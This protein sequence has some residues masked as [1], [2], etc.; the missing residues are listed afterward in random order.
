MIRVLVAEDQTLLRGAL[1]EILDRDSDI[2][3]VAQCA[4]GDDVLALAQES[5]PDVAVLDIE[6]P[7]LDGLEVAGLLTVNLPQVRV[8]VLT[9][10]GRPGYL[11]RAMDKGVLGF[12]LKDTPPRDLIY[13]IKKTAA[14]ER[15]ID[16][17]LALTTLERGQSPL[18]AR[19]QE[20]LSLSRTVATTAELARQVNL[21]EGSVRNVLSLA[22]QKLHAH[23]RAQAAL[24]AEENGWL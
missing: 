13:A 5:L 17:S 16:P 8:L 1:C 9:V 6:M 21:T 12:I 11:R 3:V 7:G 23:S 10:F 14:G 20:V 2:E 15:V 4:R 24:I 22:M 18:T 19:E